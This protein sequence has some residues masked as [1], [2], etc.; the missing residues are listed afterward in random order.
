[1]LLRYGSASRDERKFAESESFDMVRANAKEPL[2][3][4]AVIDACLGMALAR[5]DVRIALPIVFDRLPNIRLAPG[6]SF[7]FAPS[8]LLLGVLSL[9]LEFEAA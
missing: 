2:A 5:K 6:K 9:H 1:M 4:G 8:M 3:F 7:A